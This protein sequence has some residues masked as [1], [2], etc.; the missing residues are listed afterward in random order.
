MESTHGQIIRNNVLHICF[1]PAAGGGGGGGM[2]GGSYT[3]LQNA[4]LLSKVLCLVG[5]VLPIS[6]TMPFL[7]RQYSDIMDEC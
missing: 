6:P 7:R 3:L 4:L 1:N 5:L 2:G